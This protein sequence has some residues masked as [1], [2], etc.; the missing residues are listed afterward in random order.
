MKQSY[1]RFAFCAAV[2]TIA[3]IAPAPL[4][5]VLAYAG[6]GWA[7]SDISQSLFPN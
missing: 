3:I 1:K 2:I 4:N 5:I 6:L 7:V